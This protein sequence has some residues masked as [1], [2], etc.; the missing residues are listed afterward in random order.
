MTESH[1]GPTEYRFSN[2][3]SIWDLLLFR[4]I[5]L[6]PE[7]QGKQL[8]FLRH[9]Y[10]RAEANM[11]RDFPDS[12]ELPQAMDYLKGIRLTLGGRESLCALK[13]EMDITQEIQDRTAQGQIPGM[14]LTIAHQLVTV[15]NRPDLVSWNK[16]VWLIG[17]ESRRQIWKKAFSKTE[18]VE[19]WKAYGMVAHFWAAQMYVDGFWTGE[20]T[21][22]VVDENEELVQNLAYAKTFQDFGLTFKAK[23][24][25]KTL[26]DPGLL[27][28][29]DV[30]I[31]GECALGPFPEAWIKKLERYENE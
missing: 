14:I 19:C 20:T 10:R 11:E 9:G 21:F 1:E 13:S 5:Q 30:Q 22:P 7:D 25:K 27:H 6:W 26:L 18:I 17:K 28:K 2:P 29:I 24:A 12:L 4:A 15:A 3:Y 31:Y 23:G 16:I 8:D